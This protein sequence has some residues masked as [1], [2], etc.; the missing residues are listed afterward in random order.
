MKYFSNLLTA[1]SGEP[2][3]AQ[4]NEMLFASLTVFITLLILSINF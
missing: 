2:M 1:L 3:E 4:T